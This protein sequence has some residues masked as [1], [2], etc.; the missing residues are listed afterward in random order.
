[1]SYNL[2]YP[3]QF[4]QSRLPSP[5]FILFVLLAIIIVIF[6]FMRLARAEEY[7]DEEI[8]DAIYFEEGGVKAI[9]P[10]GIL[11]VKC[12]GYE[13]CRQVCLNTIKNNRK[14][15]ADYGYKQYNTF[16][17]FLW[18]RYAPPE[19]HPLNKN[20]LKNVRYFLKRITER[21]E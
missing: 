18:H 21:K 13:D 4:Q 5:R 6:L 2:L 1:M 8:A 11:S 10:F 9:K 3:Y 14:R 15:Y 19:A 12:E 20:W 16:L 17:E 7:T